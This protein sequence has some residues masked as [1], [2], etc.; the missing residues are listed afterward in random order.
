MIVKI[1]YKDTKLYKLTVAKDEVRVKLP[2][3]IDESLQTRLVQLSELVAQQIYSNY[4][5]TERGYWEQNQ[6]G[7]LISMA[8]NDRKKDLHFYEKELLNGI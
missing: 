1:E 6:D 3:D 2:S 4:I 5:G 8:G 7:Y